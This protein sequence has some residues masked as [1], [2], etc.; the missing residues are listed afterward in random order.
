MAERHTVVVTGAASGIGRSTSELLVEQGMRVVGID[1]D[2][3]SLM[4]IS[5]ALGSRFD[6]VVGDVGDWDT[7]VRAADV[8]EASGHLDGWVNNAGIYIGGGAHE[9]D[10][11]SIT[12]T[13]RVLQHGPMYGT[14]IAVRRM[15]ASK[16]GSIVNVASIEGVAAFPHHFAYQAAKAAVIMISKGVAVDYGEFGVRCNA[17]LPGTV[18]TPMMYAALPTDLD[19][20]E[21]L[22][23]EA[24]L[25]PLNRVAEPREIAEVIAFLLSDKSS[26]VSGASITVDGGATARCYAYENPLAADN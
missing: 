22:R 15:L 24:R 9:V 16:P 1:V 7:H 14:A 23:Q 4:D 26:F 13:L 18:K 11:D 21:A 20:A 19:R 3:E 25:A 17:V 12:R 10:P 5:S 6:P 8:A 2:S